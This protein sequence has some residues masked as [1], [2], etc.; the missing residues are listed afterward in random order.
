MFKLLSDSELATE[1]GSF[2]LRYSDGQVNQG[3]LDG[4]LTIIKEQKIA[5]ADKVIGDSNE[6]IACDDLHHD[7]Y[8]VQPR[9]KSVLRGRNK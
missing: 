4:L 3:E 1:V 5:H 2:E 7:A 6:F 8:K 9:I